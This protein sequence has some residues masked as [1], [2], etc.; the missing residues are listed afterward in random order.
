MHF[1][2]ELY[3]IHLVTY[4]IKCLDV[5][6]IVT[7][8]DYEFPTPWIIVLRG[9]FVFSVN[10]VTLGYTSTCTKKKHENDNY[11]KMKNE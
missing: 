2:I 11:E 7:L 9:I 5:Y 10:C 3:V 4:S 6:L 1:F 8:F